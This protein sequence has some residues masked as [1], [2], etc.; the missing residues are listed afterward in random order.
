MATTGSQARFHRPLYLTAFILSVSLSVNAQTVLAEGE[1]PRPND[2]DMN[3]TRKIRQE[4]VKDKNLSIYAHNVK[5]VTAGGRVLL[6]GPIKTA[7]EKLVVENKAGRIAGLERV[8]SE[9]EVI[10]Q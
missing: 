9:L 10:P 7:D 6:K 4:L 8:R 1:S 3:L 5:I 2:P